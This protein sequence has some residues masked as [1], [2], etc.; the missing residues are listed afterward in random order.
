M[1]EP[2]DHLL[3][4]L[5]AVPVTSRIL[6]VGCGAVTKTEALI[7]LGFDVY[8]VDASP[9]N[10]EDARAAAAVHLGEEEAGARI[11]RAR[12]DALGYPDEFFDWVVACESLAHLESRG[13]MLEALRELRRVMRLGAWLYVTV[14]AVPEHAAE[15]ADHGYAGDSGLKPTFLPRTLN[16]LMEEA[17][18][19]QAEGPAIATEPGSGRIVQGIYRRVDEGTPG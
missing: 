7:Q 15:L 2:S 18:F 5:A 1:P 10:V 12:S 17:D 11:S 9:E 19:E 4:T 16:E 8:A 6:D 13:V 14:P 3:R